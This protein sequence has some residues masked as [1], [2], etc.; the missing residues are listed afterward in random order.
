MHY[1]VTVHLP[2]RTE[3]TGLGVGPQLD[4][5]FQA[6]G[7]EGALVQLNKVM[8]EVN[9]PVIKKEFFS[10]IFSPSYHKSKFHLMLCKYITVER[11]TISI[12]H[13]NVEKQV[14][15]NGQK[16]RLIMSVPKTLLL[17]ERPMII[18]V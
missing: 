12:T 6:F 17:D 5:S 3:D 7:K 8:K 16:A 2:E 9:G 13:C 4:V 15:V 11:H 14:V 10:A 18:Q 1:R